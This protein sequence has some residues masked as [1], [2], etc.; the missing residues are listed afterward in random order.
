M[1]WLDG[2]TKTVD[3]NLGK[4]Q[5]MVRDREACCAAVHGVSKRQTKPGRLNRSD[6]FDA[7]VCLYG[8]IL[9]FPGERIF[10]TLHLEGKERRGGENRGEGELVRKDN[11]VIYLWFISA[12]G[13]LQRL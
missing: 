8:F 12:K 11:L 1:R 5:E 9:I 3:L 6:V 10:A 2:I 4:F 7:C 13:P